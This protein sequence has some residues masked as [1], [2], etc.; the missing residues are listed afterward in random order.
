M[1]Q[2]PQESLHVV[3][4]GVLVMLMVKPAWIVVVKVA[5]ILIDQGVTKYVSMFNCVLN[6][7]VRTCKLD[8]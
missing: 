6:H 4:N 7:H 3:D 1:Q 2:L 8:A 5:G